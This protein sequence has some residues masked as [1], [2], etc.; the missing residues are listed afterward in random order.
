MT[1]NMW[2]WVVYAVLLLVLY[3]AFMEV[4]SKNRRFRRRLSAFTI[5]NTE[6]QALKKT[7]R[8]PLPSVR[9]KRPVTDEIRRVFF[10]I[11]DLP[12]V[13]YVGI[14]MCLP[15]PLFWY[16]AVRP[17]WI[18]LFLLGVL[19]LWPL[20]LNI[21]RQRRYAK[22]ID[23]L[24]SAIDYLARTIHSGQ[25]PIGAI[26]SL[27]TAGMLISPI[28]RRISEQLSLG[29]AFRFVLEEVAAQEHNADLSFCIIVLIIQHETGGSGVL[30]LN[31]LANFLR[32][33]AQLRKKI[34]SAAA[35][36]MAAAYLVGSLPFV[37]LVI[38]W[39]VR[40][41]YVLPLFTNPKGQHVLLAAGLIELV[42]CMML[43]KM[44]RIRL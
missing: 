23:S 35:E 26:E 30:A 16:Y 17:L 9:K 18:I 33:R 10:K 34:K 2:L 29:K 11:I 28:F 36:G 44:V 27:S 19:G 31:S 40:A 41:D 7:K 24:P 4:F 22:M 20:I 32:D 8:K 12:G 3:L 37:V 38:L 13:L 43:A 6:E 21:V 14:V 42:G 1:G 25:T 5:K 15:V 39:W